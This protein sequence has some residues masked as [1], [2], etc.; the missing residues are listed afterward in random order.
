MERARIPRNPPV[1]VGRPMRAKRRKSMARGARKRAASVETAPCARRKRKATPL[2]PKKAKKSDVKKGSKSCGDGHGS[3]GMSDEASEGHHGSAENEKV[4][5]VGGK[6]VAEN[7]GSARPPHAA[8]PKDVRAFPVQM[9]TDCER[10][11]SKGVMHRDLKP[12]NALTKFCRTTTR[13]FREQNGAPLCGLKR[14]VFCNLA[15]EL[16]YRTEFAPGLGNMRN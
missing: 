7:S 8:L 2:Q 13:K 3:K 11:H 15:I 16:E 5:K 12:G 10:L 1:A 6:K 4:K 14:F 9:L